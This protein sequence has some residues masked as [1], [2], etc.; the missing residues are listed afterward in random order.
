MTGIGALP[1]GRIPVLLSADEPELVAA[2]AAAMLA[3]LQGRP[4]VDSVAATLLHTRRIR[5][6]RAVIRAAAIDELIAG[7]R[8]ISVA[9]PHPLV[10]RSQESTAVPTAFVFP[11]QGNHWPGMAGQAYQRLPVY[12]DE[13]DICEAAFAAAGVPS[14]AAYLTGDGEHWAPVQTQAAQFT[15]AVALARVWQSFGVDPQMTIG[16]SLGEIAAAYVAGAVRL[17]DAVGVVTARVAVLKD[18]PGSYG[19][20]V[21]GVSAGAAATLAESTP[22]WLEVS[23]VNSAT[24]TVVSGDAESVAAVVRRLAERGVFAREI[25]VD[26]PA[27]SGALGKLRDALFQRL[28]DTTF[29]ESSTEFIGTA[30]GSVVAAGCDFREYWVDNLCNAARFDHATAA[31]QA[32]GARRFIELSAH[33]TLIVPLTE[34]LENSAEEPV[35]LDSS[36]RDRPLLD[37][38][39]AAITSAAAADPTYAWAD[40]VPAAATAPLRGFPNAPMLH[41]R[42]WARLSRTLASKAAEVRVAVETWQASENSLHPDGRP[43]IRRVAVIGTIGADQDVVRKLVDAVVLH[44]RSLSSSVTDAAVVAVVGPAVGSTDTFAAADEL[45]RLVGSGLLNYAD[46]AHCQTLWMIT[47]AGERPRLTDPPPMPTQAAIAA[48]HRSIGYEYPD[49]VFAHLD[50]ARWDIDDAVAYRAVD[51]LIG[52]AGEV[53][54]RDSGARYDRVLRFEAAAAQPLAHDVFD[55]V[56][57]TGGGGAVGLEMARNCAERGARRIVLLSR[58]G[59][60]AASVDALRRPGIAI[61]DVACDITDPEAVSAAAVQAGAEASLLIHAAGTAV[62]SPQRPITADDVRKTLDAKVNGLATML[63][64]WPMRADCHIV[65]CSSVSAVWGGYGHAAYSA[66]NRMLD[67]FA[68]RLRSDGRSVVSARS[69]LWENTGV[70]GD[71]EIA[72]VRRGGLIAM[73]PAA[74]ASVLLRA[75]QI[76]PLVF[77][78]DLDRLGLLFD[79]QAVNTDFGE[80]SPTDLETHDGSQHCARD[81]VLAEVASALGLAPNGIDLDAALVDIGVDSLLALELRKRLRRVTGRSVPLAKLLGGISG[82]ELAEALDDTG[83]VGLH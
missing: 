33:P 24:S 39:S 36:R 25:A 64:C 69:G 61:T 82:V 26:Y 77:S 59:A 9:E 8:A 50:I 19:M 18:L 58:R 7:L 81:V 11:G 76:N 38:L 70:L 73:P 79:S 62:V 71:E 28:P 10:A 65:L 20:A 78:A 53:A 75:H 48:M 32:R 34:L 67:A 49:T 15:H 40:L 30:C 45:T 5:R 66:A 54:L 83:G 55:N 14:P 52:G 17:A 37:H 21:L 27:Q 6:H 43:G 74:A 12:R 16:H 13:V 44:P 57:I 1:D 41:T 46:R 72:R 47:A 56:V 60:D 4:S 63:N 35:L 80:H 22:G 3:Y 31:A 23:V 68:E 51:T 42:M 29:I 2:D